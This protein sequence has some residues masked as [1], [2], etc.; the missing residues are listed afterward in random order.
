MSK[1]TAGPWA[2]RHGLNLVGENRRLVA[3][4]G[5]HAQNFDVEENEAENE[6]NAHLVAAA[7]DMWAALHEV[8]TEMCGGCKFY[9]SCIPEEMCDTRNMIIAA[10]TKAEG[11]VKT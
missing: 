11:G 1:H 8:K 3:N 10:I 4:C 6:A 9:G 5:G 7:P 2:M